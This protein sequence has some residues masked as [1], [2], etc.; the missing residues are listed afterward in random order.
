MKQLK[1]PE[2]ISLASS[3]P[4]TVLKARA[5][6]TTKKYLYA[7][8]RWRKWAE[9]KTEISV[10]PVD[11][12]HFVLYLQH[13]A[14]STQ[15]RAA[16]EEAVNAVSWTHRVAGLSE[17]QGGPLVKMV[18]NGL[19]RILAKPKSKKKPVTVEMLQRL[20]ASMSPSPTLV[21]VRLAA[22]CLLAFSAFLRFDE[23]VKIRCCDLDFQPQHMVVIIRSSKTD[24]YRQGDQ[25]LIARSG[26]STCPVAMLEQYVCIAAIDQKSELRLFRGLVHTRNGT[27]LRKC[28]TISYTRVKE[29][30]K[31]KLSSL[32]F[33]SRQFGLHS[34]RAGGATAAA[35]AHVG[36]RL[37]KRHGRWR[38]ETAKDGY[39]E[40]TVADRLKVSQSLGL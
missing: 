39:I 38:S 21:E 10:F 16:V 1:D 4:D 36:D 18:L 22:I 8:S 3:L 20:V 6:T 7:F 28:G 34:F 13:L 26:T 23:I 9:N 14:N 19:Q 27:K 35:N 32:G 12:T 5:D 40:D 33:D 2:L 17:L 30:V 37:F 25:V 15:S 31:D 24:Q 11:P 29:I